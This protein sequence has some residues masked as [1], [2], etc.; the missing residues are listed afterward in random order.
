MNNLKFNKDEDRHKH[1]HPY[2]PKNALDEY[3]LIDK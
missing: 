2:T 3:E 1:I